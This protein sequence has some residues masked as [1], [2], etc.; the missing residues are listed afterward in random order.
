ML[1]FSPV[2]VLE[3]CAAAGLFVV[4]HCSFVLALQLNYM[5][6]F[7]MIQNK[8]SGGRLIYVKY[9]S[10]LLLRAKRRI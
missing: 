3:P 5:Q 7:A 9:F 10:F 2:L 8:S 6:M 4:S 1:C